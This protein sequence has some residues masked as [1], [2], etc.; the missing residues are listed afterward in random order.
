MSPTPRVILLPISLA[1]IA[2]ANKNCHAVSNFVEGVDGFFKLF[3]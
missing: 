3:F 1:K 2:D